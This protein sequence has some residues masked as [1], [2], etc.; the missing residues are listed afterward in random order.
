MCPEVVAY[1]SI[2]PHIKDVT[3]L[4]TVDF[5]LNIVSLNLSLSSFCF[6][7]LLEYDLLGMVFG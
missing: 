1:E 2:G 4:F 6:R 3:D 5:I 7:Y